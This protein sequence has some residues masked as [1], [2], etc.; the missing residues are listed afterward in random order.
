MAALNRK[1]SQTLQRSGTGLTTSLAIGW[2][3]TATPAHAVEYCYGWATELVVEAQHCSSSVLPPQMG[4][5]Y[6]PDNLF[7]ERGAWCE[8][9]PGS[10]IGEW[11]MVRLRP[12]LFFQTIYVVNGYSKSPEAFRNNGRVKQF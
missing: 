7:T 11:F 10:G 9:V 2:L 3:I 5:N 1:R 6:G 12:S 8:G 4:T